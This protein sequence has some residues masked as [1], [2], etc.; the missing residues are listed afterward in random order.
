MT[1]F[2]RGTACAAI[3]LLSACA[4]G[5]G[6]DVASAPSPAP[7]ATS[8]PTPSTVGTPSP[9]A[10]PTGEPTATPTATP[11]DGTPACG[12]V[13]SYEVSATCLYDAFR[14]QDREAASRYAA[15][16]AVESLF[17]LGGY[18]TDDQWAFEGCSA[19]RETSPSSGV[20]C[21]FLIPG[22]VHPVHVELAMRADF[23][24][25]RVLSIG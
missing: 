22:E 21:H 3:L 5:G 16:A 17:T 4:G 25:E 9:T 12:Q 14:R 10:A 7:S 15:P 11:A 18:P 23:A 6:T 13:D 24:V 20:A 1:P 2:S 8:T 19:G